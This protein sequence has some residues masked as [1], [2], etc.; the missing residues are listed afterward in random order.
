MVHLYEIIQE[1]G[2]KLGANYFTDLYIIERKFQNKRASIIDILNF[3]YIIITANR[4]GSFKKA[5][6]CL[7]EFFRINNI[8]VKV[9]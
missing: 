7:Y 4:G 2:L 3:V 8:E 9:I 5:F 6:N 1:Q